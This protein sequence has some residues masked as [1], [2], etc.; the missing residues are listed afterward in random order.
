ML[1]RS[2]D[3][4]RALADRVGDALRGR[5]AGEDGARSAA[6]FGKHPGHDE[7]LYFRVG[8]E[9][10]SI[11]AFYDHLY[12]EGIVRNL[13]RGKWDAGDQPGAPVLD[14]RILRRTERRWIAARMVPSR[15]AGER[16]RFPLVT[17]LSGVGVHV[18]A[19]LGAWFDRAE[20]L[21]AALADLTGLE[22]I[23]RS[24]KA[25]WER[26]A[27]RPVAVSDD[28]PPAAGR[29]KGGGSGDGALA[30]PVLPPGID[31]EG[32]LRILYA[33][34]RH[35]PSTPG[36]GGRKPLSRTEVI[37]MPSGVWLRVPS[38]PGCWLESITRWDALLAQMTDDA[39]RW[40]L[41][42]A[43][44]PWLDIIVGR[45][46]ERTLACLGLS[47]DR[48]PCVTDVPFE[49]SAERREQLLRGYGFGD[50]RLQGVAE[51]P[52]TSD[53][54]AASSGGS[55][56]GRPA[57]GALPTADGSAAPPE[58]ADPADPADSAG[59]LPPICEATEPEGAPGVE[60]LLAEEG[61]PNEGDSGGAA[62]TQTSDDQGADAADFPRGDE[63]TRR[64]A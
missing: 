42:P 51:D 48:E 37:R 3:R 36:R 52:P 62:G 41:A 13:D 60:R 12:R 38:A 5:D 47:L 50:G 8:E 4:F 33:L 55:T 59:A 15:D 64:T 22:A 16:D 53:S 27:S 63:S 23:R 40:L 44:R 25:A 17:V 7:H 6:V 49:I 32:L 26:S 30:A 9:S 18:A 43:G 19:D 46:D 20:D 58:P 14:H 39:E 45:A 29:S 10:G 24:L 2:R 34:D 21:H 11:Q 56:D 35:R 1:R 57:S 31:D 61:P 54:D 28:A